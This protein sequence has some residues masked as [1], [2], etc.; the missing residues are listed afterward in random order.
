MEKGFSRTSRRRRNCAF[1]RGG[2]GSYGAH[3]NN[4]ADRVEILVTTPQVADF[5]NMLPLCA[6]PL[7]NRPLWPSKCNKHGH[8]YCLAVLV[9]PT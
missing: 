9:F 5:V 6:G 7:K 4:G 8:F 3:G 1:M 2:G